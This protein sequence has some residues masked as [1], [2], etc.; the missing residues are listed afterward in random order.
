MYTVAVRRLLGVLSLGALLLG[1]CGGS[2]QDKIVN[3]PETTRDNGTA[4]MLMTVQSRVTVTESPQFPGGD[5]EN[6]ARAEGVVDFE[7]QRSRVTYH[8]AV[9]EKIPD[10]VPARRPCD[11]VIDKEKVYLT[12]PE[13]LREPFGGKPWIQMTADQQSGLSQQGF[14]SSDPTGP[15]EYLIGM[16]E[17]IRK[18]GTAKAGGVDTTHYRGPVNIKTLLEKVSDDRRAQIETAFARSNVAEL[19]VDVWLDEE[20]N[21]RKI[22]VSQD[23][24]QQGASASVELTLE[25]SNLGRPA[26]I[27]IPP[28]EDVFAE[29]QRADEAAK[30]CF[31]QVPEPEPAPEEAG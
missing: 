9:D 11:L 1:S 21:A 7:V 29:P 5:Y 4:T 20:G 25:L 15:L 31:D 18:L 24:Q 13:H 27:E 2:L 19:P 3:A 28:A 12:V 30:I 26:K 8:L 23:Q 10:V 16:E 14:G 6:T 22:L 17:D